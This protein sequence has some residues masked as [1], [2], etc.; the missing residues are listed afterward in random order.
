[1]ARNT[2]RRHLRRRLSG[3]QVAGRAYPRPV[4]RTCIHSGIP[5]RNRSM[6]QVTHPMASGAVTRLRQRPRRWNLGQGGT[7]AGR[8]RPSQ[9]LA[10]RTGSVRHDFI[11]AV[12]AE[13]MPAKGSTNR[14]R[15]RI[16]KQ[17]S[18]R[19]ATT[20]RPHPSTKIALSG[21]GGRCTMRSGMERWESAPIH[22]ATP[23]G[24]TPPARDDAAAGHLV[25]R[26]WAH[27]SPWGMVFGPLTS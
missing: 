9:P 8:R 18:F 23:P 12:A 7:N 20:D 3:P 14:A 25:T 6:F 19:P 17:L 22:D 27:R 26:T 2:A 24:T 16:S 10:L 15:V 5:H 11:L 13:P 4:P 21:C 1:V